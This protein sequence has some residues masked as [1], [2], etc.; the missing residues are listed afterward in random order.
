MTI[1]GTLTVTASD[2]P[3][4]SAGAVVG[5]VLDPSVTLTVTQSVDVSAPAPVAAAPTAPTAA[6]A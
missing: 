1:S 4:F 2:D 5:I 6:T 3:R